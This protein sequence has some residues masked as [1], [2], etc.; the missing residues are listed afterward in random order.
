MTRTRENPLNAKGLLF[1]FLVGAVVQQN[2]ADT[3]N[4]SLALSGLTT[5]TAVLQSQADTDNAGSS[6]LSFSVTGAFPRN[7]GAEVCNAGLAL[8]S[9]VMFQ[10]VVKVFPE[11]PSNA[12]LALSA[13]AI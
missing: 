7:P 5:G 9:F 1:S 4:V 13:F 11:F 3:G 2:Q 6:L 10:P 8:E 12:A